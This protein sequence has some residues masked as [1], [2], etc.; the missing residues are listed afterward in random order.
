MEIVGRAQPRAE[1]RLWAKLLQL[2]DS[3]AT[4]SIR[5]LWE[6]A[7]EVQPLELVACTHE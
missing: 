2:P 5:Q 4:V 3:A 1:R 6:A 7:A